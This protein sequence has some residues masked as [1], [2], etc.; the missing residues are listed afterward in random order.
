LPIFTETAGFAPT[1]AP[2]F[3]YQNTKNLNL[4][5]DVTTSDNKGIN[6]Q[7]I[8]TILGID[9]AND[10]KTDPHNQILTFKQI[11]TL[12]IVA[13]EKQNFDIAIQ[14]FTRAIELNPS[15][16]SSYNNRAQAY[17]LMGKRDQ[18]LKD[19]DMALNLLSPKIDRL[20]L[21]PERNKSADQVNSEREKVLLNAYNQRGVLRKLNGDF[22]GARED[23]SVAAD[24]GS[25]FARKELVS[26]NPI[27]R[28]CAQTVHALIQDELNKSFNHTDNISDPCTN[29]K[30]KQDST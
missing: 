24:L 28:L 15:D 17:Q 9:S 12:G 18:A 10:E 5:A 7:N 30:P 4:K 20:E 2:V 6:I 22:D 8:N 3:A 1:K 27:A 26:L 29:T 11:E 21:G 16:A 19:L 14:L 13:A 23:F 25:E